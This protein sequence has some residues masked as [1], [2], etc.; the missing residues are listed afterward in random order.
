LA[1]VVRKNSTVR[2]AKVGE[3]GTNMSDYTYEFQF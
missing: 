1:P 2:Y 3:I